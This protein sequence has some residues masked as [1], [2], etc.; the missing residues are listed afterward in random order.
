M[1][2]ALYMYLALF[3]CKKTPLNYLNY[4]K[5]ACELGNLSTGAFAHRI[6]TRAGIAIEKRLLFVPREK[7]FIRLET[8]RGIMDLALKDGNLVDA[9]VATPTM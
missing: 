3:R 7:M 6:I 2:D 9:C 8:V 5:V 4:V 1:R